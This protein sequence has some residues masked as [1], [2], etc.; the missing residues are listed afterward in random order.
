MASVFAGAVVGGIYGLTM[1]GPAGA[2]GGVVGGAVLGPAVRWWR[3]L[4]DEDAQPGQ[5]NLQQHAPRQ[6]NH[7]NQNQGNQNQG[8]QNQAQNVRRNLP[9]PPIQQAIVVNQVRVYQEGEYVDLDDC[10]EARQAIDAENFLKRQ[11][12][13]TAKQLTVRY[14][15]DRDDYYFDRRRNY[16]PKPN[17]VAEAVDTGYGRTQVYQNLQNYFPGGVTYTEQDIN[18]GVGAAGNYRLIR[19]NAPVNGYQEWAGYNITHPGGHW[20]RV[21]NSANGYWQNWNTANRTAADLPGHVNGHPP[22]DP[23]TQQ[24]RALVQNGI[25]VKKLDV[26]GFRG[27]VTAAVER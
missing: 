6:Q 8:N 21:W 15:Q 20:V 24:Q 4:P 26:Q 12:L 17:G 16:V 23:R 14:E 5:Q 27:K 25:R 2:F 22:V 1:A 10:D 7:G 19:A 9:L 18:A 3:N 13:A 11:T